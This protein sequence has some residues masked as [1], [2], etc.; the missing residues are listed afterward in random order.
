MEQ[1]VIIS[2]NKYFNNY[3]FNKVD[4]KERIKPIIDQAFDSLFFSENNFGGIISSKSS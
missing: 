1:K 4:V 2:I 3:R